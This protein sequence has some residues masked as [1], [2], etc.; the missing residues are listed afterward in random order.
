MTSPASPRCSSDPDLQKIGLADLGSTRKRKQRPDM[1][2]WEILR[3]DLNNMF[4]K[5]SSDQDIKFKQMNATIKELSDQN[6][7]IILSN[8]KL[9]EILDKNI[10][11]NEELKKSI[12][13]ISKEQREAIGR[14]EYLEDQLE[15]IQRQKL[16]TTLEVNNLPKRDKEDL[17]DV[18]NKIHI[19]LRLN[20]QKDEV[21]KVYRIAASKKNTVIIQYSNDRLRNEVLS[22]VKNY[23]KKNINNIFNTK[24]VDSSWNEETLY[25]SESLTPRARNILFTAR[26]FKK[27]FNYK[28]CW[29]ANGKIFLKKS[30]GLPAIFIKSVAQINI[31]SENES[32][33]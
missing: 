20:I 13:K 31:M 25:F 22:A 24:N 3:C 7:K 33:E 2:E 23:N 30:E 26:K 10:K 12:Q 11:S 1:E 6:Q 14:I 28:Y 17:L 16:S 19:S 32:K 5:L 9:E 27:S 18:V 21:T 29:V 8:K 15:N 4:S